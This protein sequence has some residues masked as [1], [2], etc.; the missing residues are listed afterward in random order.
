MLNPGFIKRNSN[1]GYQVHGSTFRVSYFALLIP[2][3]QTAGRWEAGLDFL[4]RPLVVSQEPDE[5]RIRPGI[6]TFGNISLFSLEP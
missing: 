6:D 3:C 2:A 5:L 1:S 4:A